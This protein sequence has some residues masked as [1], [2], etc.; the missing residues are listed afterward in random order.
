[1]EFCYEDGGKE[2][3]ELK[4]EDGILED[5]KK[6]EEGRKDVLLDMRNWRETSVPKRGTTFVLFEKCLLL[7][8]RLFKNSKNL[9]FIW[10]T[11]L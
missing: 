4:V 10:V 2:E 7:V 9:T 5:G 1:M 6:R 11:K 8:Y 3:D